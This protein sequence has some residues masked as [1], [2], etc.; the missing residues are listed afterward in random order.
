MRRIACS[1]LYPGSRPRTAKIAWQFRGRG[2]YLRPLSPQASLVITNQSDKES[3]RTNLKHT[4]PMA[5]NN[6]PPNLAT[7]TQCGRGNRQGMCTGAGRASD[8]RSGDGQ[9]ARHRMANDET[10]ILAEPDGILDNVGRGR[11]GAA[12]YA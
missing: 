10:V 6:P 1:F 11:A 8:M 2:P 12:A 9:M 3:E 5:D 7:C 4:S